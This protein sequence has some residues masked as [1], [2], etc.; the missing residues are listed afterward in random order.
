[1]SLQESRPTVTQGTLTSTETAP[2]QDSRQGASFSLKCQNTKCYRNHFFFLIGKK[3]RLAAHVSVCCLCGEACVGRGQ[4]PGPKKAQRTRRASA[5]LPGGRVTASSC[6][7]AGALCRLALGCSP[8]PSNKQ[9]LRFPRRGHLPTPQSA[10]LPESHGWVCKGMTLEG[11][12][13]WG[14]KVIF[15][16]E[17][18]QMDRINAGKPGKVK[19]VPTNHLTTSFHPIRESKPSLLTKI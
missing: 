12:L 15:P 5:G 2:L 8:V 13:R 16:T 19:Y 1:M 9:D 7:S 18:H 17:G 4:T 10:G 14:S 6:S 11:T 3:N